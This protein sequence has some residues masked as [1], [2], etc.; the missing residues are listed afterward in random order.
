MIELD[1]LLEKPFDPKGAGPDAFNCWTL[2]REV[3][4]RYGQ[5]LPMCQMSA[6]CPDFDI[7]QAINL[8]V[9]SGRW[10][11][12]TELVVPCVLTFITTP[13]IVSHMGSYIGQGLF[14]H[15]FRGGLVRIDRVSSPLWRTKLS[16]KYAFV[17]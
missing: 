9:A 14:I 2:T 13:P 7:A 3:H 1:D 4:R 15:I 6:M 12:L 11:E 10:R 8:E 16:G 5:E 17:G